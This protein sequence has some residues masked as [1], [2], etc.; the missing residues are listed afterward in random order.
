[1]KVNRESDTT[2][3]LIKRDFLKKIVIKLIPER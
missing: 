1:M 3:N 2:S